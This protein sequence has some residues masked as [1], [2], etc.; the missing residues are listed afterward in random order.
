MPTTRTS[1]GT[2]TPARR[3][4]EST[5]SAHTSLKATIA[6]AVRGRATTR[7]VATAAASAV[8][9]DARTT[10]TSLDRASNA[11]MSSAAR[12]LGPAATAASSTTGWRTPTAWRWSASASIAS[13]GSSCTAARSGASCGSSS[14]TGTEPSRAIH[15]AARDPRV[16]IT[17]SVCAPSA[18]TMRSESAARPTSASDTFQ[19]RAAAI[20]TTAAASSGDHGFLRSSTTRPSWWSPPVTSPRPNRDGRYAS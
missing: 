9:A 14:T 6:S 8:G 13:E 20:R 1:P 15:S 4:A 12:G 7:S 3:Q 16:P 10:D 17:A 2:S 18:S 5:P 11:R 19:P